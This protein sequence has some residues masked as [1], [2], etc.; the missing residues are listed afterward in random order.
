MSQILKKIKYSESFS[1]KKILGF[2]LVLCNIKTKESIPI[3]LMIN[4]ISS[5]TEDAC[6][7]SESYNLN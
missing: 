1:T 7:T 5:D 2:W 3:L 6:S 4:F